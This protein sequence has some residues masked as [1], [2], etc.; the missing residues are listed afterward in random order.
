M[1]SY[2]PDPKMK[3]TFGLWTVGNPGRDPFGGPTREKISPAQICHL[4]GEV[5]AYGVNFH[6][7]DSDPHRRTLRAGEQIKK[8]FKKSAE[9]QRPGRADGDDQSVFRSGLQGWRVHQQQR[10]DSR[11]CDSEDD[12]R[13]GPGRRVR[14]EDLRLLGRPRGVE[15]DATKNPVEAIKRFREA[16]NFLCEYQHQ[17]EIRLQVCVRGQAERAARAYLFCGHGFVSGADPDAGSSRDVRRESGSRP[18][19]HGRA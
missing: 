7:N 19:A 14:R 13:D 16:I 15:S 18:R 8:D 5:G 11:L 9:G 10:Q 3:F 6:D 1:P 17:P 2:D 4:L 12:A